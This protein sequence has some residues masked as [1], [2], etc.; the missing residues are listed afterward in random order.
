M[1]AP[2]ASISI[3]F[4]VALSNTHRLAFGAICYHASGAADLMGAADVVI[5]V[6]A[7]VTPMVTFNVSVVVIRRTVVL[8]IVGVVIDPVVVIEMKAAVVDIPIINVPAH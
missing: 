5:I 2:I 4:F 6:A 3:T 8:I 1:V 7:I